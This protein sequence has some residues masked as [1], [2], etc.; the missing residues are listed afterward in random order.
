[1]FLGKDYRG[2][3]LYNQREGSQKKIISITAEA[4]VQLVTG[5]K[6][7]KFEVHMFR[8]FTT[9]SRTIAK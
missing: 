1:M 6:K 5:K 9:S 3:A 2:M 4:S 7:N 8:T